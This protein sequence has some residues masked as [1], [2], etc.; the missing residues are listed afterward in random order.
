MW[1]GH[2]SQPLGSFISL[3]PSG[4]HRRRGSSAG[5]VLVAAEEARSCA[6]GQ[7]AQMLPRADAARAPPRPALGSWFLRHLL[8]GA[9][10]HQFPANSRIP[11]ASFPSY[12]RSDSVVRRFEGY[13]LQ[14]VR[15]L[16]K[17][18]LG[19][20]DSCVNN[21]RCHPERSLPRY[22]RQTESKDLRLSFLRA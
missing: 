9:T 8:L 14:P 3:R 18:Q 19:F 10:L 2:G 7:H 12:A 20:A 5:L 1:R 4:V 13:G 21:V 15:Y 6:G 22:L 16:A 11:R 17:N